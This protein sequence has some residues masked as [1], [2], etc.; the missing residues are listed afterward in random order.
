MSSWIQQ[1]Y[2]HV[3][4]YTYYLWRKIGSEKK[5]SYEII[6]ASVSVIFSLSSSEPTT[7]E[8]PYRLT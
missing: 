7:Y 6:A 1:V 5:K 4:V 3:Y 8:S 2:I